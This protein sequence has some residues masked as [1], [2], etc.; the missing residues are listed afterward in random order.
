MAGSNYPKKYQGLVLGLAAAGNLGT[1]MDG[2]IFPPIAETYGWR[3][4]ALTALAFLQFHSRYVGVGLRIVLQRSQSSKT[5][6][7]ST[8]L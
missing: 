4:A 2:L 1:M 3:T 7:Y 8:F 5:M 6:Q